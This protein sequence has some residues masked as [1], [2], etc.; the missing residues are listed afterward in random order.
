MG[1][2]EEVDGEFKQTLYYVYV[3][4]FLSLMKNKYYF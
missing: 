3:A 1:N 4:V 2:T